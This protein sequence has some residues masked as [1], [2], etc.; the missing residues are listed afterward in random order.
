MVYQA[1]IFVAGNGATVVLENCNFSSNALT[2]QSLVTSGAAVHCTSK[3]IDRGKKFPRSTCSLVSYGMKQ[4][5][6]QIATG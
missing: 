2:D 4:P 3:F 6:P 1:G 5:F